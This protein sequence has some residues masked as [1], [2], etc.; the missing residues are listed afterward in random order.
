M[1]AVLG[2][3]LMNGCYTTTGMHMLQVPCRVPL[4]FYFFYESVK[5]Y[6]LFSFFAITFCTCFP[7][8]SHQTVVNVFNKIMFV[9]MCAFTFLVVAV[10]LQRFVYCDC[11]WR[12][13]KQQQLQVLVITY[14]LQ[15]LTNC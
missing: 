3:K 11:V 1:A 14:L 4:F 5:Y 8:S 10:N 12:T 6:A 13:E 2:L 15:E 7:I 9:F